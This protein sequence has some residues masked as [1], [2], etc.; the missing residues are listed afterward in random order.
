MKLKP[1]HGLSTLALSVAV[2]ACSSSPAKP[3]GTNSTTAALQATPGDGAQLTYASQPLTLTVNN[4]A[5]TGGGTR[6]YTFEVAT[7]QGFG[8]I[9]YAK[10]G[11]AEGANG[12]TSL[13]IDTLKGAT[14]YY[15]RS[16]VHSGSDDGPNSASRTV[17]VGPQVV[18][19]T[20]VLASP[21]SGAA[22]TGQTVLTVNNVQRSG[23]AG[24]IYYTFDL[25]DSSSF[26]NIV[27]TST[28]AE[29]GG[30]TTSV[31][32]TAQLPAGTYYWR[33]LASDPSNQVTTSYSSPSSFSYTQFDMR[34]ALIWDNPSDLGSWAQTANITYADTSGEFVVVDFDKRDGPGR[35][36]DVG[37]GSGSLE[38]TLGMC[39]NI[40][41]QWNCSAVIQ[42]WSGRDLQAG[43][44]PWEIG[45]NWYYD[46]RWGNL[47]GYQ[48]ACGDIVGLFVAAGNLRDNGNVITKER[49]N[50]LMQPWCST[51]SASS[52]QRIQMRSLPFTKR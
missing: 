19:Q 37:F 51:Y 3:S 39:A 49:S 27:F 35:W 6:T 26:S 8:S 20:P 17:S 11:V 24:Q 38:Y 5:S 32:V 34:Q 41:G 36:P 2:A 12:K 10:N 48:P 13:T 23:P 43:G 18:L 42:F 1:L 45:L 44:H 25:S 4:A 31:T 21:A 30:G 50:V 15:W 40:G 22:A 28:V 16:R 14:T 29:Q 7:D 9:A 46:R 52:L 33:A 47:M